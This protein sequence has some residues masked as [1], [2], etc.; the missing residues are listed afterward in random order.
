MSTAKHINFQFTGRYYTLGEAQTAKSIWVV[1]HGHGQ[2]AEFFIRKFKSL[3]DAGHYIIA[4]EGLN[5][6]YLE[7]YSGRV[8]AH[9]M[10]SNDREIAITNYL[11]FLDSIA[12]KEMTSNKPISLLGFSQGAATAARWALTTKFDLSKLVLWGGVFPPDMKWDENQKLSSDNTHLVYGKQ[13]EFFKQ[14][15]FDDQ[16]TLLSKIGIKPSIHTFDGGHE[17]HEETMLSITRL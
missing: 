10:T 3:A 1:C 13:D 12:N 15:I 17:L 16:L 9:W 14:S 6:Y 5:K 8:G 7:G 11:N 4:P 2:L